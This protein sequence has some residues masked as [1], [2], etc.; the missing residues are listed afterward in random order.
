VRAEAP[1]LS[2]I[3]ALTETQTCP[4]QIS[5]SMVVNA[6]RFQHSIARLEFIPTAPGAQTGNVTGK[7]LQTRA[8]VR[9]PDGNPPATLVGFSINAKYSVTAG[10]IVISTSP[11]TIWRAHFHALDLNGTAAHVKF[12][13]IADNSCVAGGTLDK[14]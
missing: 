2:G 12:V 5:G 10:R 13:A 14:Y 7:G 6:G 1:N 9:Q 11:K 8:P 3:Y 4:S